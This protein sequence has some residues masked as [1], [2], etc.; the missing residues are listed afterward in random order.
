MFM[1]GIFMAMVVAGAICGSACA[2][3]TLN[4]LKDRVEVTIAGRP[5]TTLHFGEHANKPFLYPLITPNGQRVTRGFPLE[6]Q[7]GDPT[8]HPHQKGLWTG[9]EQTNGIDFWENDPSY[10]RPRMGKIVFRD[11]TRAEG[12]AQSGTL[13]YVADWISPEGEK[14]I[15]ENHT[16]RFFSAGPKT[17]AIDVDF[18]LT[19][20]PTG[21]AVLEDH[22]DAVIGVRLGPAFD[23]KNGG[24]PENAEGFR[25]EAG[26]RGRA[27]RWV[28]W[29]ANLKGETAGLAILDHPGNWNSPARWHLRSFGFLACNPFAR[30]AFDPTASTGEKR[31]KPGESLRLRYRILVHDGSIDLKAA[32]REFAAMDSAGENE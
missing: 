17:E 20:A 29:K 18:V 27:S 3:V 21:P 7:P 22:Q 26:I 14:V 16:L 11:V 10:Q 15:Q 30:Q 13:A 31:L 25:G 4:H 9:S 1:Y 12:G 8:D 5:F 32:Y 24:Y 23:E 19:A 28:D 6:P 2:Q